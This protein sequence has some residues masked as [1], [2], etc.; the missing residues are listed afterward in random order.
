MGIIN[1]NYLMDNYKVLMKN[2]LEDVENKINEDRQNRIK[3]R[4]DERILKNEGHDY[5]AYGIDDIIS[6]ID[7]NKYN[8]K[9]N[10]QSSDIFFNNDKNLD[11]KKKRINH[12]TA[13]PPKTNKNDN[14]IRSAGL[15]SKEFRRYNSQTEF[16][17]IDRSP[18][19]IMDNTSNEVNNKINYSQI[20]ASYEETKENHDNLRHKITSLQIGKEINQLEKK[21]IT[22]DYRKF[23]TKQ[24]QDNL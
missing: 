20:D 16:F 24:I 5:S 21:K 4:E 3:L 7:V 11:L 12:I 10:K 14:L 6:N 22:E 9:Y 13:F 2:N 17:N 8:N 23:L 15:K 18:L 1:M 19:K